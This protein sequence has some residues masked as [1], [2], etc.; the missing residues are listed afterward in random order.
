MA[1]SLNELSRFIV[2]PRQENSSAKISKAFSMLLGKLKSRGFIT[3]ECHKKLLPR[4]AIPPRM[5]G[6]PKLHKDGIPVRPI[7]SMTN[8]AYEPTSKWLAHVLKPVEEFFTERCVKDA[9]EFVELL[10]PLSA[11]S[12]HMVSYNVKSLFTNV[13]LKHTIDIICAT[14][15]DNPELCPIL[16]DLLKELLTLCTDNI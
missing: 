3:P 12:S 5:Y 4:G 15:Y 8:S 9:F 6:L 10:A 2:D 1:K 13:S 14:V 16:A 11:R 7:V